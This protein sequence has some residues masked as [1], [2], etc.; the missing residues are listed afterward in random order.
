[1]KNTAT[2]MCYELDWEIWTAAI[3]TNTATR[4]LFISSV[5]KYAANGL[6]SAP[7]GDWY[8]TTN[9]V[10]EGFRAR[11]HFLSLPIPR[12]PDSVL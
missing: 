1:M 8:E 7:L 11:F 4:D 10:V 3:M 5:R 2:D 6:N 12:D 9:G